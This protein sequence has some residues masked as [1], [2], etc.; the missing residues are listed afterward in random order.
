MSIPKMRYTFKKP[1]CHILQYIIDIQHLE[2][3]DMLGYLDSNRIEI[4]RDLI[5]R[6]LCTGFKDSIGR[7]I[8]EGDIMFT[9]KSSTLPAVV[10]YDARI[11]QFRMKVDDNLQ[12]DKTYDLSMFASRQPIIGNVHI[13]P[14]LLKEARR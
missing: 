8:Y 13:N 9:S 1:D 5:G 7:D 3:G 10:Y 14:E 12:Y 6:D 4:E 2:K 11:G